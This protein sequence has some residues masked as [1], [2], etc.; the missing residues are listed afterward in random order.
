MKKDSFIKGAAVLAAAG[1]I[2]K[3]LGAVFKIPLTN[4]IGE[5][6]MANF[7]PAY[8]VYSFFLAF[9]TAG[10]PVAISRM[11]SERAAVGNYRG[12]YQ[13]FRLSRGLMAVIGILCF[14]IVLVGAEAFAGMISLP[15]SALAMKWIA[16]SLLFVPLMASYRGYFQGLQDMGPTAVS[17]I[18]EQGMRVAVGLAL[19]YAM[20][21]GILLDNSYEALSAEAKGAAGAMLGTA[22]G[23]MGGLLI[24]TVIYRVRKKKGSSVLSRS[25]EGTAES[26]ASILKKIILISVPITAGAAIMPIVGLI[27]AATVS[28]RLIAAGSDPEVARGLYGQLTAFAGPLVNLPQVLTQAI[29]V[30]LVPAVA[31]AFKRG[32]AEDL[33]ENVTNG[34]RIAILLGLPC[35]AGL[36]VLA[37]PILRLLYPGQTASAVSAAP[38][39]QVLA[40]GV[41]F[42]SIVQTLTAVLQGIGKQLIPVKNLLLGVI[43]KTVLTWTLVPYLGIR[44]AAAGTVCAYLTASVLNWLKI[45][46]ELQISCSFALVIGKPCLC[47]GIMTIC[48]IASFWAISALSGSSSLAALG[49]ILLSVPVYGLLLAATHTVRREELLRIP[50]GQRIVGLLEKMGI[51]KL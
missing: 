8:N 23:A 34:L 43:L 13:V 9:S 27:D 44:G 48:T 51:V 45:R 36:I 41:L 14:V 19:A 46:K 7:T 50:Q 16:P 22:A 5:L 15:E 18:T 21:R 1:M 28:N 49:A 40:V 25:R 31:A 3:M 30:S 26:R 33:K 10:I 37:E 39:L 29:A 20:F 24:I 35:S 6:G 2:V 47:T 4:L 11:V 38:C 12:A 42:L 17:Q 32:D